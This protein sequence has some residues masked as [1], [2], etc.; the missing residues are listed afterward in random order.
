MEQIKNKGCCLSGNK[1]REWKVIHINHQPCQQAWLGIEDCIMLATL[2]FGL[3][4][5]GAL[6][7][8][9]VLADSGYR[10]W[11]VAASLRSE[12]KS[13]ASQKLELPRARESLRYAAAQR[14]QRPDA[15]WKRAA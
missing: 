15:T 8:C 13:M 3:V 14:R 2:A 1:T 7:A 12:L 9:T 6:A 4:L 10:F 5:L 11:N